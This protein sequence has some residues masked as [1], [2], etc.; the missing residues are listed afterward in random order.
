MSIDR[1]Q[2]RAASPRPVDS[3]P[4]ASPASAPPPA[5]GPAPSAGAP[6]RFAE[7]AASRP[8]DGQASQQSVLKQL[9]QVRERRWS[10]S[11]QAAGAAA[12]DAAAVVPRAVAE[13]GLT[14]VAQLLRDAAGK[15]GVLSRADASRLSKDLRAAGRK[16]EAHAADLF[17]QF[18]DRRDNRSGA[19]ITRKD[20]DAGAAYAR[21][22]LLFNRDRDANGFEPAEI[23][24]L[25]ATAKALLATGQALAAGTIPGTEPP[26][27]KA[28]QFA[29]NLEKMADGLLFMSETDAP[30]KAF[31]RPFGKDVPL[32][33]EN[34][35]KAA[36]LPPGIPSSVRSFDE[37]FKYIQDPDTGYPDDVRAQY[38]AL[39]DA[40]R[41]G[42]TD[43][44]IIYPYDEKT[45]EAPVYIVGRTPEGDLAGLES[46]RV[47]T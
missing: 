44:Q 1:T 17:F 4:A 36:G 30:Y 38:K 29:K 34:F 28:A 7:A 43:L 22:H 3:Q 12:G 45:V 19:R 14:H 24:K 26:G 23:K 33:P 35:L 25:S 13:Q 11:T 37:Y 9:N 32:T 5:A 40:M 20:I 46:M 16:T 42:L 21:E 39:E 31:S 6:D 2:S 15:D 18:L 41:K 27:Q 10:K 47:W 8:A